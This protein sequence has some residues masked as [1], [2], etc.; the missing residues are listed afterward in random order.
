MYYNIEKRVSFMIYLFIVTETHQ[1]KIILTSGIILTMVALLYISIW[2]RCYRFLFVHVYQSDYVSHIFIKINIT[3]GMVR[4][5]V[6]TLVTFKNEEV[7][8]TSVKITPKKHC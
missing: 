3:Q 4:V 1:I 5:N 6:I 2:Y 7:L 8:I